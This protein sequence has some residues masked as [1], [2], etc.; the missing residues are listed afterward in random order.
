MFHKCYLLP[1]FK[2]TAS[3]CFMHS[4]KILLLLLWVRSGCVFTLPFCMHAAQTGR[5]VQCVIRVER[6]WD[7]AVRDG[8]RARQ[9]KWR[10][11]A[12][13][14]VWDGEGRFTG[15]GKGQVGLCRVRVLRLHPTPIGISPQGPWGSP[16][17]L[18]NSC[19]S[20]SC[21]EFYYFVHFIKKKKVVPSNNSC[22]CLAFFFPRLLPP[23]RG[24]AKLCPAGT[25][26]SG[27]PAGA[28]GG[29]CAGG[30]TGQGWAVRWKLRGACCCGCRYWCPF[31]GKSKSIGRTAVCKR[32]SVPF[33]GPVP[34]CSLTWPSR[35]VDAWQELCLSPVW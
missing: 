21:K 34:G 19:H 22:C 10:G 23:G 1:S 7:A 28:L 18:C 27:G 33:V 31:P 14:T 16:N 9:A 12:G 32:R 8:E 20:T 4:L 15:A 5:S 17:H 13:G 2:D 25:L 6:V 3:F 30:S 35:A 11:P 26:G 24:A 29:V